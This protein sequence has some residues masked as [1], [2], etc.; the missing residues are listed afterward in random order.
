MIIAQPTF[1]SEIAS[2]IADYE[3]TRIICMHLGS[4]TDYHA[5]QSIETRPTPAHNDNELQEPPR[6]MTSRFVVTASTA[7]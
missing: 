3:S 6:R 7:A 4:L 1:A 5:E 2:R